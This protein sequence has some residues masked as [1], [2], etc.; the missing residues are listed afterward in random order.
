MNFKLASLL[1]EVLKIVVNKINNS[2]FSTATIFLAKNKIKFLKNYGKPVKFMKSR[3]HK[4]N[5]IDDT[6]HS[7]DMDER[8]TYF[9]RKHHKCP[10]RY[11]ATLG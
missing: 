2:T 3:I 7:T 10:I 5:K 4:R 9:S 1:L 8:Y 11:K 6:E